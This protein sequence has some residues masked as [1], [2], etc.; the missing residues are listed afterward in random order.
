MSDWETRA[1]VVAERHAGEIAA[2]IAENLD[3][4]MRGVA[5]DRDGATVT[6]SGRGLHRRMARDA[7]LRWPG[8]MTR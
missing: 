8:S 2:R 1:R 7:M 4:R 5:V 6:L 3:G